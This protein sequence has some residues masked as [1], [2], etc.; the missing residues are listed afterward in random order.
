MRVAVRLMRE[1]QKGKE[2]DEGKGGEDKKE[3]K[4]PVAKP[5]EGAFESFEQ[6]SKQPKELA[7]YEKI[8]ASLHKLFVAL[9]SE[10]VAG[11]KVTEMRQKLQELL[12][13]EENAEKKKLIEALLRANPLEDK[14]KEI[15]DLI[16]A[17]KDDPKRKKFFETLLP[18]DKERVSLASRISAMRRG[19]A[20]AGVL[21][22]LIDKKPGLNTKTAL[23]SLID[24]L[25]NEADKKVVRSE[26]G[27][28][29]L[30]EA[31]T[32]PENK[33]RIALEQLKVLFSGD[34]EKCAVI[35]DILSGKI[36]WADRATKLKEMLD[37]L[38]QEKRTLAD[39]L[40]DLEQENF[41]RTK[42][43]FPF[44]AA[45]LEKALPNDVV[46][47][48]LK[49]MKGVKKDPNAPFPTHFFEGCPI[50][51]PEVTLR[52]R[53]FKAT[54]DGFLTRVALGQEKFVLPHDLNDL[55]RDP[56]KTAFFVNSTDWFTKAENS[57]AR[58]T[59]IF[60]ASLL[61]DKLQTEFKVPKEWAMPSITD[62]R[63]LDQWYKA[64][65]D[66]NNLLETVTGY[67]QGYLDLEELDPDIA[68]QT[69]VNSPI[70]KLRAMGA[71]IEWDPVS[72]RLTKCDLPM[73]RTLNL[74]LPENAR[75]VA[76]LKQW[77]DDHHGPIDRAA[78]AYAKGKASWLRWGDFREPVDIG[79]GEG[80]KDRKAAVIKD[81]QGKELRVENCLGVV[82]TIWHN[83]EVI[84][85]S[86]AGKF[87]TKDGKEVTEIPTADKEDR[88]EF[89]YIRHSFSAK[90]TGKKDKEGKE[91]Y[92]ISVE[93]RYCQEG[94][95]NFERWG[96]DID[97]LTGGNLTTIAVANE[98]LQLPAGKRIVVQ[99]S[100]THKSSLMRVD[101]LDDGIGGWRWR[102]KWLYHH[103]AKVGDMALNVGLVLSGGAEIVALKSVYSV[104]LGALRFT[105]GAVGFLEPALRAGAFDETLKAYKLRADDVEAARHVLLMIDIWGIQAGG[106]LLRWMSGVKAAETASAVGRWGKAVEATAKWGHRSVLFGM[107]DTAP[108]LGQQ[109][110]T[111][112]QDR[113][114]HFA[115]RNG[116]LALAD[117]RIPWEDFRKANPE[118]KLSDPKAQ[119][120]VKEIL[121]S[122]AD[123]LCLGAPTPE[124][125][126]NVKKLIAEAKEVL[127]LKPDDPRRKAFIARLIGIHQKDGDELLFDTLT[128]DPK[129]TDRAKK[130]SETNGDPPDAEAEANRQ[131]I[132]KLG[133]GKKVSDY[134]DQERIAALQCLVML[135]ANEDGTLPDKGVVIGTR[136]V[137]IPEH[138]VKVKTKEHDKEKGEDVEVEKWE[139]VKARTVKQD[140]T[141]EDALKFLHQTASTGKSDVVK[142][143]RALD[144]TEPKNPVGQ[145]KGLLK[146]GDDDKDE[147]KKAKKEDA[148]RYLRRHLYISTDD[149]NKFV[150][151]LCSDDKDTVAAAEKALGKLFVERSPANKYLRL[152]LKLTVE[153]A[154]D[155]LKRLKSEDANTR[156]KAETE[157][158]DKYEVARHANHLVAG[159]T[160]WWHGR[161]KGNY[162]RELFSICMD[163]ASNKTLP[164]ALRAKAVL[165]RNCPRLGLLIGEVELL[166]ALIQERPGEEKLPLLGSTNECTAKHAR[167]LLL[168]IVLKDGEREFK[169]GD[170]TVKP[171][172]SSDLRSVCALALLANQQEKVD[173]RKAFLGEVAAQWNKLSDKPGAFASYTVTLLKKALEA[174]IDDA[175]KGA[176]WRVR[177]DKQDAAISLLSLGRVEL[178]EK[179]TYKLPIEEYNKRLLESIAARPTV[180]KPLKLEFHPDHPELVFTVLGNLK[181][182]YLTVEQRKA[183]L[184]LLKMP[185]RDVG[186]IDR[187][188]DIE[189]AK[190]LLIKNL[191]ELLNRGKGGKEYDD[192]RASAR[193]LLE[194]M[195]DRNSPLYAGASP[196]LKV[197]AIEALRDIG[198]RDAKMREFMEDRLQPARVNGRLD[199]EIAKEDGRVIWLEPPAVRLAALQALYRMN[200]AEPGKVAIAHRDKEDDPLVGRVAQ[201]LEKDRE[202]KKFGDER[203]EAELTQAL[204]LKLL[205]PDQCSPNP[206]KAYVEGSQ[207]K[208]LISE[209]LSDSLAAALQ[210]VYGLN[211]KG[212]MQQGY[213][214]SEFFPWRFEI[215]VDRVTNLSWSHPQ[216]KHDAAVDAFWAKYA[217]LSKELC[218]EALGI[219]S[220]N[221]TLTKEQLEEQ[222]KKSLSAIYW[223]LSSNCEKCRAGD[224]KTIRQNFA[225][226]LMVLCGKEFTVEGVKDPIIVSTSMRQLAASYVKILLQKSDLKADAQLYLVEALRL[227]HRDGA[228]DTPTAAELTC[229]MLKA[230]IKNQQVRKPGDDDY[231]DFKKVQLAL[232]NDLLAYRT[233]YPEALSIIRAC[234]NGLDGK[235]PGHPIKEVRERAKDILGLLSD[236]VTLTREDVRRLPDEGT[237]PLTRAE[238]LRQNL[239]KALVCRA[240]AGDE[241]DAKL[242]LRQLKALYASDKEKCKAIDAILEGKT[243]KWDD[244]SDELKKILPNVEFPA[245]AGDKPNNDDAVIYEIFRTVTG[246]PIT[247]PDDPRLPVLLWIAQNPQSPRV[248]AAIGH[249]L[250][251]VA[252]PDGRAALLGISILSDVKANDKTILGTEATERLALLE[253]FPEGK[254]LIPLIQQ[255]NKD[256]AEKVL[257]A[258]WEF[259]A[260]D[261]SETTAALLT[262]DLAKVVK[263]DLDASKDNKDYVAQLAAAWGANGF[264]VEN[265]TLAAVCRQILSF[266]TNEK[267]KLA[268]AY[269]ILRYEHAEPLDV[270]S[271]K[272]VLKKLQKDGST[273][274]IKDEAAL[275]L[276]ENKEFAARAKFE[277]F[278]RKVG[279][280]AI[281]LR[282]LMTDGEAERCTPDAWRRYTQGLDGLAAANKV[283]IDQ[284]RQ[285]KRK[286]FGDA[287]KDEAK[288]N[289]VLMEGIFKTLIDVKEK[290]NPKMSVEDRIAAFEKALAAPGKDNEDLVRAIFQMN[291]GSPITDAKD[292]RIPLLVRLGQTTASPLVEQAVGMTLMST[293]VNDGNHLYYT[294]A[295]MLA[296]VMVRGTE[297]QILE[298]NLFVAAI[299]NQSSDFKEAWP[300]VR[301]ASLAR[302]HG[303]L[304]T[305]IDTDMGLGPQPV[306]KSDDDINAKIKLAEK[307]VEDKS[308][309]GRLRVR[310][311]AEAWIAGNYKDPTK[312]LLAMTRKLAT[313]SKDEQVQMAALLLMRAADVKILESGDMELVR[314]GLERLAEKAANPQIKKEARFTLDDWKI[315][316]DVLKRDVEK[317]VDAKMSV[318]DRIAKFKEALAAPG[319]SNDK[320]IRAIFQLTAGSP[321]TDDKDPRIPLLTSLGFRTPDARV[322]QA[323]GLVLLYSK[324]KNPRIVNA[325]LCMLADVA[326]RGS[327][328]QVK[329]CNKIL[330]TIAGNSDAHKE[331]IDGLRAQARHRKEGVLPIL[332]EAELGITKQEKLEET[333]AVSAKVV[334]L[335]QVLAN[336]NA[337]GEVKVQALADAWIAGG[338]K[339][340]TGNLLT[341]T[342]KLAKESKDDQVRLA[343]LCMMVKAKDL[344]KP[345][346]I[347]AVTAGLQQLTESGSN[348]YIKKDAA[349]ILPKLLVS[350]ETM[351]TDAGKATDATVPVDKRV[352]AIDA[353]LLKPGTN[354]EDLIKAILQSTANSPIKDA[355]DARIKLLARIGYTYPDPRVEQAVAMSLLTAEKGPAFSAA[356]WML[357]DVAARGKGLEAKE[358][359][360]A[361]DKV[362]ASSAENKKLVAEI[363]DEILFRTTGALFTVN[364]AREGIAVHPQLKDKDKVEEKIKL[365]QTILA[366]NK[367][368]GRLRVQAL[369]DAWAAGEFKDPTGTLLPITRKLATDSPDEQVKLA[370]LIIMALSPKLL[371][372][373]EMAKVKAGLKAIADKSAD[374]QRKKEAQYMLGLLDKE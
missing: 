343:A 43:F 291:A 269:A 236:G 247:R 15:K 300:H 114:G 200:P 361:L 66:M 162:T 72:K 152:H 284:I 81:G 254:A 87:I 95:V 55:L 16:E 309:P 218:D 280:Q 217:T 315:D 99:D 12:Q 178:G 104:G 163:I 164:D 340:P 360:A 4:P 210:S 334:L 32:G 255:D 268:A 33:G 321:I 121:D 274:S 58:E 14:S 166:D 132:T 5:K 241:A 188:S 307:A 75:V 338:Y 120:T 63:A 285:E 313:E 37:G 344:L 267:T 278:V 199:G 54:W 351:M 19:E 356:L 251:D 325:G 189:I 60:Q 339:D 26:L 31:L 151:D 115:D 18:E 131:L 29:L 353:A 311:L 27:K 346:D 196:D 316:V 100:V 165:D 336:P 216:K 159:D 139:T 28:L 136:E 25:D 61:N 277:E 333:S 205:S 17:Y 312:K 130:G 330:D 320:L 222:Q 348:A 292:P 86:R 82:V 329:A 172:E 299:S 279:L 283:D 368:P 208:D 46:E 250:L 3:V 145:V 173:E 357:A 227:L 134:S 1:A 181:Y 206:G 209:N 2:K 249:A 347:E 49:M 57:I 314:T 352:A 286:L 261:R 20:A 230:P 264:N 116:P 327:E 101:D 337:P 287:F 302:Q 211:W 194:S 64:A 303:A 246:N 109:I 70:A 56:H 367:L 214:V 108:V 290:T 45:Y 215:A 34:K 41:K 157:L 272:S 91:I 125:Q 322:E 89:D 288:A 281:V 183:V 256:R 160:L 258:F 129:Y 248:K 97:A 143:V 265:K 259:G 84:H 113:S 122:Y 119:K 207:Y 220:R 6:L 319:Y 296:D 83:G 270:E 202:N 229:E 39:V 365:A 362:A 190:L 9:E 195:F 289:K 78:E 363:R 243:V 310:A 85:K 359:K 324:A 169:D 124:V 176:E 155:L 298:C 93:R 133:K 231:E 223:F 239:A 80:G 374:A 146:F 126:D 74:Q 105:I 117:R 13:I 73:P 204:E 234:A 142:A 328:D 168:S 11:D 36:K 177:K 358:A 103:G 257:R 90:K 170:K 201:S 53:T 323:V 192:L 232:L 224:Q 349:F 355:D 345:E 52:D 369:A 167:A 156:T 149:A 318:D 260:N 240:V 182:A 332:V 94:I 30:N 193:D 144:A 326:L 295:S 213:G 354:N 275:V 7:R 35:D 366:D 21:I 141:M 276:D 304:F 187:R 219:P 245:R 123:T 221:A 252:T 44:A 175:P 179:E 271:A 371:A 335:E 110:Y 107:V 59:R 184:D 48:G 242:A 67:V 128:G 273:Q 118:F 171:K 38:G 186:D 293:K 138:K 102:Q 342:R 106:G 301:A 77:V 174:S 370:A 306:L 237:P 262:T 373:G 112:W 308:L 266:S 203:K 294:G 98:T 197:A 65:S 69:D 225:A 372:D 191:P 150:A 185:M 282:T 180:A 253:K 140:I 22:D 68:K 62:A 92:E 135:S 47:L 50:R 198:W 233:R 161:Y 96:S 111:D 127:A 8:R 148:A 158:K 235:G 238:A 23:F 244:R 71:V 137:T 297:D 76:D 350:V 42:E 10:L 263:A 317:S 153:E 364:D 154:D 79:K 147:D 228:I 226:T 305:I 51:L 341:L 24:L 212:S 88:L 40:K 331:A